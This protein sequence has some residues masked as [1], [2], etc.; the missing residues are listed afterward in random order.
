MLGLVRM[1]ARLGALASATTLL[2]LPTHARAHGEPPTA[3]AVIREDADG[4][5][6]VKLGIG[7]AERVAPGRFQYVCPARWKGELTSPAAALADGT[8]VI[9]ANAG[10]MLLEPD[11]TLRVHPDPVA[12]GFST[13]IVASAGGVFALRFKQGKSELLAVDATQARVVWSDTRV[14]YSLAPLA[15][16]LVV[17]RSNNTALEQITL[18]FEGAPLDSQQAVTLRNVDYAFARGLGDDA[19]ALLLSQSAPELGRIQVNAFTRVAQASSSIAGPISTP[20]GTLLA[21]DGQLQKLDGASLTPLADTAYVNCLERHEHGIYACTRDGVSRMVGDGVGEE[22]FALSWLVPPDLAQ[23]SDETDRG[24]CDYQWQDLRFDLLA[25]GMSLRF[26][27]EI[28]A[29]A[30]SDAG[31]ADAGRDAGAQGN[32]DVAPPAEEPDAGEEPPATRGSSRCALSPGQAHPAAWGWGVLPSLAAFVL[33][34]RRARVR[35]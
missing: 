8:V 13:E 9:G 19:Y 27:D 29:D 22:V 33:A 32:D 7:F 18:S 28:E 5:L 4:P 35:R 20:Q 6:L 34:R 23:L 1:Y 24:R 14:W 2:A 31:Q 15:H 30:G 17:L 12:V 11:G 10:L 3:H 21:I 25:L 26:E 16:G